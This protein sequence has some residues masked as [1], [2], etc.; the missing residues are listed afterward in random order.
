MELHN[1]LFMQG[2]NLGAKINIVNR[3]VKLLYDNERHVGVVIFKGK[4]ALIP[5]SNIASMDVMNLADL[6]LDEV[7]PEEEGTK[8]PPA[9]ARSRRKS[10]INLDVADPE[11]DPEHVRAVR[12]ASANAYKAQ[13]KVETVVNQLVQ[14]NKEILSGNKAPKPTAAISV[15]G[16]P[17]SFN[18]E[19]LEAEMKS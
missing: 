12:E 14:D 8:L 18:R 17:K 15:T 4:A 3:P 9:I 13:P 6:K 5:S 19:I 1:P 16:K 11:A 2:T 7:L 10:E